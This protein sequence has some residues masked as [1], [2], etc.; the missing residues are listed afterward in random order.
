MTT[1]L[2]AGVG[3]PSTY[4][5]DGGVGSPSTYVVDAGV[6]SPVSSESFSFSIQ[7]PPL[8]AFTD[9][10]GQIV[11]LTGS[12]GIDQAPFRVRLVDGDGGELPTIGY[13][14]GLE[15][16]LPADTYPT[17]DQRLL[18]DLPSVSEGVYGVRV[19]YGPD[20]TDYVDATNT[21]VVVWRTQSQAKLRMA[22]RFAGFWATG[23]RFVQDLQKPP[24]A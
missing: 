13:A 15:L 1:I 16:D 23:S 8:G 19:Y 7:T 12:W 6:G 21:L 20:M 14:W 18:F 24:Y 17:Y 3:S 22:S 10:G 2:D 9:D 5:I 4:L 11:T